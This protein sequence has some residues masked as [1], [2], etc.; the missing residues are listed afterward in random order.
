M[1]LLTT[2]TVALIQHQL[3]GFD[4]EGKS[5]S[6]L[7]LLDCRG[8]FVHFIITMIVNEEREQEKKKKNEKK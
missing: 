6:T 3:N 8:H 7:Y 1:F 4:C 5:A 2:D